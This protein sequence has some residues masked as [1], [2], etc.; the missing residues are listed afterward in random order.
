MI[1][2]VQSTQQTELP[3]PVA[4]LE[5]APQLEKKLSPTTSTNQQRVDSLLKTIVTFGGM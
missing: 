1:Y 4:S 3:T 5:R 2:D